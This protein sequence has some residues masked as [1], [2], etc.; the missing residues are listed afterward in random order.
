M[1]HAFV[2][3]EP[4]CLELSALWQATSRTCC[5]SHGDSPATAPRPFRTAT[6]RPAPARAPQLEGPGWCAEVCGVGG[7]GPPVLGRTRGVGR[8]RLS[9][10]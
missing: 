7:E 9:T 5:Q 2:G 10:P 4:R 1:S 6:G 8:G 3:G